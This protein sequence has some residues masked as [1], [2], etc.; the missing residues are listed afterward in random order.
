MV[1]GVVGDVVEEESE[2]M[3]HA[4]INGASAA[5]KDALTIL[6]NGHITS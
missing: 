3:L 5:T 4:T 1:A 2:K 6:G